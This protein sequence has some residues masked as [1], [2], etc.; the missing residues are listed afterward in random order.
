MQ[1]VCYKCSFIIKPGFWPACAWFLEI[2]FVW[3][4]DMRVCVSAPK[5]I[6]TYSCEM[7]LY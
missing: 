4:V 1:K 2:T 3:E 6:N 7:N 5:G